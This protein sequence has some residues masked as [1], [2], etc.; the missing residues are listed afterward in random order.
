MKE[1]SLNETEM[2]TTVSTQNKILLV[3]REVDSGFKN[4]YN[5]RI[6]EVDSIQIFVGTVEVLIKTVVE[7]ELRRRIVLT[8]QQIIKLS[9]GDYLVVSDDWWYNWRLAN[10]YKE[11]IYTYQI[12]EPDSL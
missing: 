7:L 5:D 11:T 1:Q 8:A 6:F 2:M 4:E 12:K 10:D 9:K 3:T